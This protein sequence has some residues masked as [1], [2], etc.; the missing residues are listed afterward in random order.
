MGIEVYESPPK[1]LSDLVRLSRKKRPWVLDVDVD[2]VFEMQKECYTQIR[3]TVPGVLQSASKVVRFIEES[4]PETV[5]LSEARVSAIRNPQSNFSKFVAN[6]SAMGYETEERGI[7]EG[8]AEVLRSIAVCKEFYRTVSRKLTAK[9]MPEMMRGD[10][11][12]FKEE[13]KIA[14]R[15]FFRSKGYEA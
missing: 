9:H 7:F 5:I 4:K 2:Y 10:L 12:G 3:G 14:A 11:K 6:L 1:A 15:K 8:D 13:E